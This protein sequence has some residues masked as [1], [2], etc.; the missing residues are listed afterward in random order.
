MKK[1]SNY[2]FISKQRQQPQS[3]PMAGGLL[4]FAPPP[5]S[6][7]DLNVF[8]LTFE[9][10]KEAEK[11]LAGGDPYQCK[12]C[13][14][15]LNKFSLVTPAANLK[16]NHDLKPNESLWTCEFCNYPNHLLIEKEEIPI[17]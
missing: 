4:S 13:S 9:G 3:A 10:L 7:V 14:A 1:A 6:G 8:V 2:A 12:K 5:S 15:I 16:G 11:N 17:K